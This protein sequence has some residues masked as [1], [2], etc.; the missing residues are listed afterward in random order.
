[1][2]IK[3]AI[4]GTVYLINRIMPEINILSPEFPQW[5]AGLAA[6]A[7]S[8]HFRETKRRPKSRLFKYDVILKQ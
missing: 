8:G 6:C 4:L 3:R 2:K 1:M 7:K 5:F